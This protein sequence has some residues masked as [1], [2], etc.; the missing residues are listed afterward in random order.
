MYSKSQCTS[1][2]TTDNEE[3]IVT[4]RGS[5][6]HAA[7]NITTTPDGVLHTHVNKRGRKKKTV[8]DNVKVLN[9]KEEVI[10]QILP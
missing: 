1:V 7:P 8:E 6:N 2:L 4:I 9:S 3:H 10:V 5:H